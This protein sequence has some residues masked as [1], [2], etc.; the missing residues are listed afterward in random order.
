GGFEPWQRIPLND[1]RMLKD[2]YPP[3]VKFRYVLENENGNR[4]AEGEVSLRDTSYL[5]DSTRIISS[6]DTFHYERRMIEH[7]IRSKLP[8]L[9]EKKT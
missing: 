2:R 4:L 5:L 9:V 6:T 7:W 1:V 3:S 8:D